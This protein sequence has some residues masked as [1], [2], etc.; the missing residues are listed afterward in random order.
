MTRLV[1]VLTF[2]FLVILPSVSEAQVKIVQGAIVGEIRALAFGAESPQLKAELG[3]AGWLECAGQSLKRTDFADL[4]KVLR[5]SWGSSD[6]QNTFSIPDLRG[7]FLRGWQHA[8][9]P[10]QKPAL[11]GDPDTDSRVAPRGEINPPGTQGQTKDH[12]GSLQK[13]QARVEPHTH[14]E[15]RESSTKQRLSAEQGERFMHDPQAV[16]TGPAKGP[17]TNFETHPKN[18]YVMYVIFVGKP[19]VTDEKTGEIK[20]MRTRKK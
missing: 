3:R 10:G 17:A 7:L 18:V 14:S 19:V 4:F 9:L 15:V 2:V 11:G 8:S 13:D 16:D 1:R 12:V 5:D 6:G 20:P